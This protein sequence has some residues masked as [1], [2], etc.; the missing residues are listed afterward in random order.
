[1]QQTCLLLQLSTC[2][3]S[4]RRQGLSSIV[5][6][7]KTNKLWLTCFANPPAGMMRPPPMMRPPMLMGGPAPVVLPKP[8]GGP[9]FLL[10]SLTNCC[11]FKRHT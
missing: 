7:A 11:D 6:V 3:L 1:M 8:G 4:S 9:A 5:L 10:L 2:C